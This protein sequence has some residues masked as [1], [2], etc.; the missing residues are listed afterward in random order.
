M[1]MAVSSGQM[2]ECRKATI[3]M[4]RKMDLESFYGRMDVN[5]LEIGKMGNNMVKE[6]P[7]KT[8]CN[9]KDSGTWG[10]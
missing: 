9:L 10:N 1:A 7:G 5:K 3:K 2:E 6:L 8:I 4:I